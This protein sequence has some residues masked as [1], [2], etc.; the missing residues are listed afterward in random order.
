MRALN[1][2]V[3]VLMLACHAGAADALTEKLQRGLFE[4]EANHNLEAAIKEY[5]SVVAQ[6]DEQRKMTATALFRLAECYRKLGKTNEAQGFY[7]RVVRDFSEQEPLVKLSISMTGS[8]PSPAAG[9]PG[10]SEQ[11]KRK[12]AEEEAE[13]LAWWREQVRENPDLINKPGLGPPLHQAISRGWVSVVNFLLAQ[14]SDLNGRDGSQQTPLHVAVASNRREMVEA[15]LKAGADVNARDNMRRTPL[16]VAAS[17]GFLAIAQALI[18]ARAEMNLFDNSGS[19]PLMIA[20]D[21]GY[22]AMTELLLKRG[23]DPDFGSRSNEGLYKTPLTMAL[24]KADT[25]L[26]KLLIEHKADV[27][28]RVSSGTQRGA[29]ALSH[30][31]AGNNPE[32]VKLLLDAGANPSTTNWGGATPLLVAAQNGATASVQ[33]LL[34]RGVSVNQPGQDGRTALH[35][36]TLGNANTVKV[37]LERGAN[38]NARM[39]DGATPLLFAVQD[40]VQN[41]RTDIIR[42][43][44]AAGADPNA[45]GIQ[46]TP[47]AIAE[48]WAQS[49]DPK[50]GAAREVVE[51]LRGAGANPYLQRMRSIAIGH[52][53]NAVQHYF[54]RGTNDWNRYTLL[55]L[56]AGTIS[57]YPWADWA[58]A[59]IER[60][61]GKALTNVPVNLGEIFAS[62]QCSNDLW[63]EWGDRLL[64]PELDHAL[65]A[66]P[67]AIP[68]NASALFERCLPRTVRVVVKG[69]TNDVRLLSQGPIMFPPP[70][71]PPGAFPGRPVGLKPP[72]DETKLLVLHSFRLKAVVYDSGL[73][74]ASSDSTRTRVMRGTNHWVIN[75]EQISLPNESSL[76]RGNTGKIPAG[77]DLWL[78]DGDVIEIPEKQ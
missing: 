36:A 71:P 19:T 46:G 13:K 70:A 62:G 50:S 49:S 41:A 11:M 35:N 29:T 59:Y 76:S 23:A 17:S 16:H 6:S 48:S 15:L 9:Q 52:R 38:V 45:F 8:K 75:L 54:T 4:E 44:L 25:E 10:L 22:R 18:A 12:D 32:I 1:V 55:E 58:N 51:M 34:D 40:G 56:L 69:L 26:V 57:A 47:L 7:Q 66:P 53:T 28:L 72:S 39:E 27:H 77:H 20:V 14:H 67:P 78:R 37:L 21:L 2:C 65:N 73:L 33:L 43:L 61:R 42:Q 74:R 30:A 31:V 5:Q 3:V 24:G 60:V 64:L 68:T 63:L